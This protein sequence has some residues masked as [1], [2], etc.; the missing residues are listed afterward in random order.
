M[1]K[2]INCGEN[3]DPTG[4][5]NISIH[6]TQWVFAENKSFMIEDFFLPKPMVLHELFVSFRFKRGKDFGCLNE[7]SQVFRLILQY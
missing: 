7:L 3:C 6:A 2:R 5:K 4:N 1:A